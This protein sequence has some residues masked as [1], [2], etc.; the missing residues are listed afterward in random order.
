ML[1]KRTFN[2]IQYVSQNVRNSEYAFGGLQVVAFGDFL[3]LPPVASAL[4]DG[5]YA[6]EIALWDSTFPHQIILKESFRAKDDEELVNLLREISKGIC[7]EHTVSLIKSL[8]RPLSA[9]ELGIPY[10]PKVFPLNKDID[11]TNMS[12][13][14]ALPG[15]EY[16]FGAFDKGDKKQL[17]KGLIA[18]E[19]SALKVGAQVMF[20]YNINH[21]IKNGVQGTVASFLNGLPVV[22]TASETIV[23]NQVIWP[24]YDKKEPTK[25]IGTRT[26]L[27]LKLAWA[28]TVHKSQG[29]T[30]DAVEVYCGK[31][32]AP[33]HLYVAMSGFKTREQLRVVGFNQ[34]RLIPAPKEVI[35]FLEKIHNV[36]V[37][38]ECKCCH[39]KTPTAYNAH[40]SLSLDYTSAEDPPDSAR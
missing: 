37:E 14:D 22:T 16:M 39:V 38:K 28:M 35:N 29:K 20:I 1:S 3:Q 17:N 12:I 33:G 25:V 23:V 5:K 36:P 10:V 18:S 40:P 7:S 15:E 4:D 13:L 9:A 8:S 2:I 19:K 31:E 34:N 21:N 32:F 24:V 11:Y 26:Q 6:F 30:L 27:P